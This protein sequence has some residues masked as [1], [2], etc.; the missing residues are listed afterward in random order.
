LKKESKNKKPQIPE[1]KEQIGKTNE[2]IR[3]KDAPV[4]GTGTFSVVEECG[5]ICASS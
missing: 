3:R 5:T 4:T 1:N 2:K